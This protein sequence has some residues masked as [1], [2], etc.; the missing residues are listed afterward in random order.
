MYDGGQ[1]SVDLENCRSCTKEEA[2]G[3]LGRLRDRRYSNR[4]QR[5]SRSHSH[6]Y[7]HLIF[8]HSGQK[9]RRTW[10]IRRRSTLG[11]IGGG[12]GRT[13]SSGNDLLGLFEFPERKNL[14]G[15]WFDSGKAATAPCWRRAGAF[16]LAAI[17]T[18][19]PR[20]V[21]LQAKP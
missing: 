9:T 13:P 16:Q 1:I 19:K 17:L 8:H 7:C 11:L 21:R 6:L 12:P 18:L 15:L 5:R 14:V 4:G 3:P 2:R 10:T 20:L